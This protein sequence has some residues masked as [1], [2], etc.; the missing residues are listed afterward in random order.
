[1]ILLEIL[2]LLLVSWM[3]LYDGV[4]F[5]IFLEEDDYSYC[6]FSY[7]WIGFWIYIIKFVWLLFCNGWGYF[8]YECIYMY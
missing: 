8:F 4:W 3:I 5:V 7:K 1:M 2:W 6:L